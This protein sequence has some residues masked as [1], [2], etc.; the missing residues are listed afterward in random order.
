[1][2]ELVQTLITVMGGWDPNA[3]T[4]TFRAYPKMLKLGGLHQCRGWGQAT[5]GCTLENREP[6]HAPKR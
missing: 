4:P 5:L 3:P 2:A 6:T 1:M